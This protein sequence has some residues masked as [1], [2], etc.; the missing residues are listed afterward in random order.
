M[1]DF[2]LDIAYIYHPSPLLHDV[3]SR[4]VDYFLANDISSFKFN[5]ACRREWMNA[6]Q[7]FEWWTCP[8]IHERLE[9]VQDWIINCYVKMK[10]KHS[11][12]LISAILKRRF[13]AIK[14]CLISNF[15][16]GI[17]S[18]AAKVTRLHNKYFAAEF[19][20]PMI[21]RLSDGF[22]ISVTNCCEEHLRAIYQVVLHGSCNLRFSV[23]YRSSRLT[24]L[25]SLRRL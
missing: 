19:R 25:W 4:V 6:T 21:C 2:L 3:R 8:V 17:L 5:V 20:V 1:D 13:H 9:F 18:K 12:F 23:S 22:Y 11:K 16:A 14:S 10:G 24:I 15:I 7:E